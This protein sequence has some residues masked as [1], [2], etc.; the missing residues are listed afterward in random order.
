[1]WSKI[2]CFF[3]RHTFSKFEMGYQ[4]LNG[5]GTS[6]T[7]RCDRCDTRYSVEVQDGVN[8][9]KFEEKKTLNKYV[10]KRGFKF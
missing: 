10:N 7:T 2:K 1:M 6:W 8:P 9:N 4:A 3:L 5:I